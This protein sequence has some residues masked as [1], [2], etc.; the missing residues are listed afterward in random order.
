VNAHTESFTFR[1][2]KR[3]LDGERSKRVIVKVLG[4]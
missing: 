4:I 1:A 3:E 2:E